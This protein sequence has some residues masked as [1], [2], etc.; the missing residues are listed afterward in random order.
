[1]EFALICEINYHFPNKCNN[2][3]FKILF[4]YILNIFK[5]FLFTYMILL[6]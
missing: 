2:V 4:L 5:I 1:M 6:N 3:T